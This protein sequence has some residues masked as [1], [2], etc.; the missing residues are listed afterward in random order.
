MDEIK[1][2]HGETIKVE[3]FCPD[4]GS[5]I[6]GDIKIID[7]EPIYQC[8]YCNLLFKIERIN[9]DTIEIAN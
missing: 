7:N 4:C 9:I 3:L 2:I 5:P 6:F 1:K 8:A